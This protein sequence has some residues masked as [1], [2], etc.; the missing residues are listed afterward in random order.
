MNAPLVKFVEDDHVEIAEQR[1]ALQP[2]GED[3]FRRHEQPRA[4]GEL[5][6]EADLPADF[7][8]DRPAAF[9]GDPPRQ[10]ARRHAP[11]LQQDRPA[12]RRQRRRNARRLPRSRR[13]DDHRAAVRADVSGDLG[14]VRIDRERR[15]HHELGI[16]ATKDNDDIDYTAEG[17]TPPHEKNDPTNDGYDEAAHNGPARTASRKAKA[18]SSAPAAAARTAAAC[19]KRSD[20]ARPRTTASARRGRTRRREAQVDA[21]ICAVSVS[22]AAAVRAALRPGGDHCQRVTRHS[23]QLSTCEAEW[24]RTTL[25]SSAIVIARAQCPLHWPS[26]S[27]P[28]L[29][30]V[31][32]GL[33][34]TD[35]F[36]RQRDRAFAGERVIAMRAFCTCSTLI[37]RR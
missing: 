5:P 24:R 37:N 12:D 20:A 1:I 31:A 7:V 35:V 19:T 25:C 22:A 34:S 11:R 9:D 23:R 10:R 2:R 15:L 14:D 17:A 36:L 6:F 27:W 3:S 8:A 33:M 26:L 4:V 18:A 16:M 32:G 21:A 29:A 28:A 30:L 13:R